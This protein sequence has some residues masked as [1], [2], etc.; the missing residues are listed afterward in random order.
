MRRYTEL[1][2]DGSPG[3]E[4]RLGVQGFLI[5][6]GPAAVGRVTWKVYTAEAVYWRLWCTAQVP[7]FSNK[8]VL[9]RLLGEAKDL[10]SSK[11]IQLGWRYMPCPRPCLPPWGQPTSQ[12]LE[13]QRPN[14]LASI[15]DISEGLSEPQS[16]PKICWGCC[17]ICFMVQLLLLLSLVFFTPSTGLF[18]RALTRNLP[19]GKSLFQ[20]LF[21]GKRVWHQLLT[22]VVS[23]SKI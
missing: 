1:C 3:D 18:P 5:T 13:A 12:K 20:S 11:D 19:T 2:W 8:A 9:P 23:G 6:A 10:S 17:H 4:G 14:P 15:Q 22:E 7:P 16:S 21:P